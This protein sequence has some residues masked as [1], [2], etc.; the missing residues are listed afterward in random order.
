MNKFISRKM[1]KMS[2]LHKLVVSVKSQS[3]ALFQAD[4]LILKL[5]QKCKEPKKYEIIFKKIEQ[6]LKNYTN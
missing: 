6:K 1:E 5:I 2:Y 4:K 3:A